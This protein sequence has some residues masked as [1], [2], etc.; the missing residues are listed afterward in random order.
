MTSGGS[1][2]TANVRERVL[3]RPSIALTSDF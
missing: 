1:Y 2:G 3:S